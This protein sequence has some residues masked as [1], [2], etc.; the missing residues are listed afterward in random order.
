MKLSLKD[1]NDE[2]NEV[3]FVLRIKIGEKKV[4]SST[5]IGIFS[6]AR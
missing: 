5:A 3:L 4:G 1:V 2:Y 6:G